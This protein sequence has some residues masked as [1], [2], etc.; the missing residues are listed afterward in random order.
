M[1]HCFSPQALTVFGLKLAQRAKTKKETNMKIIVKRFANA[2]N[3][4]W[5]LTYQAIFYITVVKI[6]GALGFDR[7]LRY[8]QTDV[9]RLLA[10]MTGMLPLSASPPTCFSHYTPH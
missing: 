5:M 10:K 8:F 7:V 1:T 6:F 4:S 3:V 2:S 9:E